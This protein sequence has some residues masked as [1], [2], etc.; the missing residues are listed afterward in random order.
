MAISHSYFKYIAEFLIVLFSAFIIFIQPVVSCSGNP[1]CNAYY[2]YENIEK[3]ILKMSRR[4]KNH[5]YSKW[6]DY[7]E[8][9]IIFCD[10]YWWKAQRICKSHRIKCKFYTENMLHKLLC[11]LANRITNIQKQWNYLWNWLHSL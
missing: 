10:S 7:N 9:V 4:D 1:A 3:V 2:L 11:K 8:Y 5:K 6:I